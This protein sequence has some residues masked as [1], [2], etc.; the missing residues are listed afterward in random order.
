VERRGIPTI[1]MVV[2]QLVVTTGKGMTRIRC[3]P[4]FSI[5]VLTHFTGVLESI[6]DPNVIEGLEDQSMHRW[7]TYSWAGTKISLSP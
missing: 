5:A 2:Q 3:V 1:T 6:D 7:R 4:D